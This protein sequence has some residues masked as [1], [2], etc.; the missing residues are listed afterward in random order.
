MSL[1]LILKVCARGDIRLCLTVYS[2]KSLIVTCSMTLCEMLGEPLKAW[3]QNQKFSDIFLQETKFI[4]LYTRYANDFSASC[5]TLQ[6][7]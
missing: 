5:D 1:Q 3:H 7:C 2:L 4:K 6:R